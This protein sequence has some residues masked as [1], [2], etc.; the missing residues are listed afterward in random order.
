MFR[1]YPAKPDRSVLGAVPDTITH[2]TFDEARSRAKRRVRFLKRLLAHVEG[3]PLADVLARTS[4]T[5]AD[6]DRVTV[7]WATLCNLT[8]AADALGLR[9]EPVKAL[10]RIGVL[11]HLRLGS[12]LRYAR[13]AEIAGLLQ[14][15]AEFPVSPPFSGDLPLTTF[16]ASRSIGLAQVIKAW[17]KGKLDGQIS[18]GEGKG[19]QALRLHPEPLCDKASRRL[20]HDPT[21]AETARHLRISLVAIR[22]LRDAGLLE[23]IRKRNPDTNFRQSYISR[24]SIDAFQRDYITPGQLATRSGVVPMH[25]ARRLD[26]DGTPALDSPRGMVRVYRQDILTSNLQCGTASCAGQDERK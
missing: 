14:A 5:P 20:N 1:N 24:A 16:C 22:R 17:R 18:R 4:I 13:L 26:H 25:L 21:L 9:P 23:Q 2:I 7:F 19:L 8:E 15:V 10:I 12:A 6:L 11:S 3:I